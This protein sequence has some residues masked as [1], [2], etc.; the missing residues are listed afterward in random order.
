MVVENDKIFKMKF[1]LSIFL[2]GYEVDSSAGCFAACLKIPQQAKYVLL[3]ATLP[4]TE[5][6]LKHQHVFSHRSSRLN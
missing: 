2:V 1:F 3:L 5:R 4:H 6:A